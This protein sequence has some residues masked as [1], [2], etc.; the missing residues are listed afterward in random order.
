MRD[1]ALILVVDDVAD[2]LE[3]LQ[4]RLESQGY[5]VATSGDGVE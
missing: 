4:M 5:E 3:I 2:N 1:P